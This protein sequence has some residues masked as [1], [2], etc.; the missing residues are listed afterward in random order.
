M[1]IWIFLVPIAAR[2]LENVEE[3]AT[4]T[5]FSYTF[6][7]QLTLPFSWLVFYF[8]AI[9]FAAANL[10]FQ[11][12]CPDIVK[13]HSDYSEFKQSN[14]GIEHL[15]R[16]LNQVGL[17]W[18]GLRLLIERQD[19][20][21]SEVA[22]ASNPKQADGLLRKRFWAIY[23]VGNQHRIIEKFSALILYIIGFVLFSIVLLQNIVFVIQYLTK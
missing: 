4:V 12:R 2:L 20:Y 21:F 10:I 13:E 1:Y 8:S 3:A 14:M 7:A 16:Y 19:E 11:I 5:I 22:E 9:A 6:E 17:N 23:W 15:D 18:E